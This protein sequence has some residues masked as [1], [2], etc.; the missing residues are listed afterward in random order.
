[1]KSLLRLAQAFSFFE[2]WRIGPTL[3]AI[4]LD[5]FVRDVGNVLFDVGRFLFRRSL[6]RLIFLFG[7]IAA[8]DRILRPWSGR[9]LVSFHGRSILARSAFRDR[10]R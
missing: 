9:S 1:M 7:L 3:A 4:P 8:P 5:R 2:N 6:H 10:S